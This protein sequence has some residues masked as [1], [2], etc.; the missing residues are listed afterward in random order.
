MIDVIVLTYT[1]NLYFYGLTCRTINSLRENNQLDF[2]I[3]VVE[4]NKTDRTYP[5]PNCTVLVPTEEFNYNKFL[6]IALQFCKNKYVLICNN[7]LYFAQ[8]SVKNLI[9]AMELYDVPS[10]SPHEPNWHASRLTEEEKSKEI[11]Y[12]FE[13]EK[14]VTGWCICMRRDL[15]QTI[16]SFDESFKFWY[17]DNDY[18]MSL[19][20]HGLK[21]ILVNSSHVYHELSQSHGL[22]ENKDGMTHNLKKIFFE[23]WL[24]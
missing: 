13:V 23:K 12:G 20:K 9:D 3:I 8:N 18:A 21:H 16:G 24:Q 10:A 19:Q 22:I 7:D 11:V 15:L 1:K 14:I 4:T 2:N 6:N 5:Y 17:Q